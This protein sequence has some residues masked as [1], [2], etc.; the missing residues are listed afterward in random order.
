MFANF[1]MNLSWTELITRTF[2]KAMGDDV[3]GLA[4]QLAFYFF[5]A[6]FPAL[7]CLL[8]VASFFPLEHF[9]D[10]MVRLLG[11]FAP[12]EV[13]E[14]IRTEMAKIGDG[15]HGGLLT[16]GLL[17][18]IW[19]SSAAV[20]SVIGAMNRA[21]DIDERRP[22]WK[23]RALAILLWFY[24]SGLSIIVGA[25]TNAEIEHASAWA[26]A[27]GEHAPGER[28]K[29]GAAAAQ[30]Y[31]DGS[32]RRERSP[33]RQATEP[34][35]AWYEQVVAYGVLTLRLMHRPREHGVKAR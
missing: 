6:L 21:Y 2:R 23:V 18:A 24:V 1:Q 10:D 32:F 14:I 16:I 13:I 17:G 4:S 3:Q 20:V 12:R 9:T 31:R 33:A 5:L 27:P 30:A 29:I 35:P 26:K 28:K 34:P 15:R 19:S 25:E 11:P 22:W 7:L 8:A